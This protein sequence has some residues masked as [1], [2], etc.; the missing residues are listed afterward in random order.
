MAPGPA[1]IEK[2]W[3]EILTGIPEP[4]Q[5]PDPEDCISDSDKEREQ[6]GKL[7]HDFKKKYRMGDITNDA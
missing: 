2:Y 4:S 6:V 1:E 7:F 3:E 5:L